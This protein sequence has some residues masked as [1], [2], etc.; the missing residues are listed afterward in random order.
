VRVSRVGARGG[1]SFILPD[2]QRETIARVA[3]A[4]G[5]EVVE[6][7]EDLDASGG[8]YEREGFQRALE[9]A[10]AG[11]VEAVVVARL[12]RFARSVLDTHRALERIEL[13]GGRLIAGDIDVDTSTPTGRLLRG[14]LAMLA[15]F[16]LD[17]AREN[18]E[19]AKASAVDR[20]VKISSRAPFGFRFD[21]TH[22][23]EPVAGEREL[24]VELFEARREGASY[25]EL[26][27][28]FEARTGLRSY[29]QTISYMLENRAYTGAVTYSDLVNEAAHEAIVERELFEAVQAVG[30]ARRLASNRRS[31]RGVRSLLGG[32]AR[33]ATCGSGLIRSS[34]GRGAGVYRCQSRDCDRRV[35]VGE[36]ALD[37]WLEAE[38]FAWAGAAADELVEVGLQP[39]RPPASP[40]A[41]LELRLADARRALEVYVT[42][43]D[44]FGLEAGLFAA[45]VD[46]RQAL[47]DELRLELEELGELDELDAIRTTLRAAWPELETAERRRLVA[48]AVDELVVERGVRGQGQPVGERARVIFRASAVPENRSELFEQSRTA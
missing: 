8:K 25:Q 23:L 22:R 1:E 44:N 28:L 3:A 46:A 27:E 47:I 43:P 7:F 5:L 17:V 2:V 19:T 10:E 35:Y 32:I 29:K 45:G 20:G 38:L 15:E 24:V 33:C 36:L 39:S 14:M 37:A 11:D 9:L 4:K 21:E 34:N 40:R 12:T 31:G 41:E 6:W 42:S 48:V 16:E 30:A 18:W 26:L 13:A